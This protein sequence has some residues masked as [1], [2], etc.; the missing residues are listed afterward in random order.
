M[1]NNSVWLVLALII[2][3]CLVF[4]AGR[5][6]R[7][8]GQR[9][10]PVAQRFRWSCLGAIIS[11]RYWWRAR[12]EA[13]SPQEQA[14]LL[15]RETGSLGL[16]R[17]DSLR[18]PLCGAEVT[19]AWTLGRDGHPAVAPGPVKC[20]QCDFRLDAC[21]HCAHFLPGAPQ[22]VS[23]WANVDMTFGRCGFYKTTQPVEQACTPE[24]AQR[25]KARGYDQLRA[26]QPVVDSFVPPEGCNAFT[27][28]RKRLKAG[29]VR[30]P[31]TRRVALLRLLAPPAPA[32]PLSQAIPSRDEQWLL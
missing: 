23:N 10:L 6:W 31:D 13:L 26:P 19:R 21:R 22:A 32:M 12:I 16:N 2:L 3:S 24:V 15:A 14:D 5:I 1:M 25:L 7:D 17:A 20:P 4:R 9:G 28:D 8:A 30:W 11:S 29:G 27:P 18:C